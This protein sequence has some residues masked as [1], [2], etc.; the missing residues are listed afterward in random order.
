M[1]RKSIIIPYGHYNDSDRQLIRDMLNVDFFL[2]S[3]R[4]ARGD[5]Y[6]WLPP[7]HTLQQNNQWPIY[8]DY[9]FWHSMKLIRERQGVLLVPRSMYDKYEALG[10]IDLTNP[11]RKMKLTARGVRFKHNVST[12]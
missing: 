1:I 3:P 10:A 11:Y 5:E 2:V 12:E 4:F 8:V 6:P 7:H 9:L